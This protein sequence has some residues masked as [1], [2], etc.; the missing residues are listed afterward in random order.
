LP[1][2]AIERVIEVYL[3][4][5]GDSAST[6][7]TTT[8]LRFAAPA[9]VEKVIEYLV[10]ESDARNRLA[11]V[12][13]AGQLGSGSIEIA[14][15]YLSDERWYVVRNMCGVLAELSDPN[16]VEHIAPALRHSDARVQQAALK[17]LVKARSTRTASVLADALP[18]LA[19][20]I[21][22]EALDHLMYVRNSGAVTALEEFVAS[23]R[24]N[25]AVSIK[26]VQAL[27][28]IPEVAA[29]YALGRLYRIEELDSKVRRAALLAIAGNRSSVATK[30]LEELATT[31]G[32]L[33][34]EAK[35]ELDKRQLK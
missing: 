33:A 20:Q 29:L 15:K 30:L 6:R 11:L 34:E 23:G 4:K 12:R 16:L 7:N 32:P 3:Q 18:S 10:G 19:P 35:K 13:L 9:S 22:D 26:A 31:W 25:L 28:R 27:G 24:H 21:L 2:V 1:A 8:L 14:A 5:R 17:A